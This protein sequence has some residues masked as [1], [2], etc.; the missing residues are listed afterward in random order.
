VD[1]GSSHSFLSSRVA[2][3]L[4]GML[5]MPWPVMV[6][7][8]DGGRLLCDKQIL[9]ATWSIQTCEF[10]TDFRVLDIAAYDIIVGMDWLA[11]HSPMKVDWGH[12]WLLIP[13]G[14][15]SVLLRGGIEDVQ[16]TTAVRSTTLES[17]AISW[18]D[19]GLPQ[20]MAS[21]LS[22]FNSVF[23]PPSGLPP[24]RDCDHSIPLVVGY[25]HVHVRPYRYPPLIKDEIECQIAAM[26]AEGI[27]QHS[28]S[29]FSSSV[30][31]VK[32][33]DSS[34][35]FCVDFR[36]LN[37]ITV[38]SVFSVPV[39]E[40][41]LDELG[42]ASWFTSL[43]LTA[44]YHQIMLR[45]EDTFKTSFQ[46]HSSHYEF[47]VMAFV[48]TGT[49][50]T[51]QKAMNATLSSLLHRCVLVFFGDILIYSSS[52]ADHLQHVRAV[53]EL[54]V[55]DK[56]Q[57]KLSKC[58]FAQQQLS[59]LGHI[60][61]VA[62]VATDPSKIQVVASWATPRS[63]K[64]LHSFLGLAG[65]YRRFVRHFGILSKPLTALLKKGSMFVWTS[66]HTTAFQAL[67]D[68]LVS[69]P[70]L[71][72]PNFALPFC[73]ETDAS[74]QG[75]GAVL[76]QGGHPIT[77]LSKALGPKSQGLSTYEKEFL[78]ILTAVDHWRHY[79]QLKEFHIVTDHRSLAQLDE[80]RLHTPWQKKMFSRL[81]GLQ[82][83]IMYKKGSENGAADALSRHPQ[84]TQTCL[85]VSSCTPQWLTNIMDSYS[86]DDM[87]REIIAKL[88]V[89]AAAVPH[90]SWHDGLLRYKNRIWV[91]SDIPLQTRLI[92]AFHSMAVGG[93]LG[94]PVTY[95]RLKQLFAWRGMKKS[96][97]GICQSMRYVSACEGRLCSFAW[98]VTASTGSHV[99]IADH[100]PG[101]Y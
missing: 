27:I 16:A 94:I 54:L 68:A 34:W 26:L 75:V 59:Y 17:L 35:R 39:I 93:H 95:A 49:P 71:A 77:Y 42:H 30:L 62:G 57:V 31:L 97:S 12:G 88:A 8:A 18:A 10:C 4:E 46:T 73:L 38:K 9:G 21:L 1:S 81:L 6:Q 86:H 28:T 70:V 20:Q 84:L 32:K 78:A 51:F 66:Q 79:L 69:A 36:R 52:F 90:Y 53:L 63:L 47:C 76:M 24:S 50:A 83:R 14:T 5:E 99:L 56:W 82:Y 72:L 55:R 44:G 19:M 45:P 29:S 58:S 43:D 23:D 15:S 92:E 2:S 98:F 100:I 7:V 41:L 40:E 67:K 89:D 11:V 101:F 60:I 96:C 33:K 91:G 37:A 74:N 25:S 13:Y 87:S 85:A 64:E 48:L 65:Y 80:Q 3:K 22:E 61:S